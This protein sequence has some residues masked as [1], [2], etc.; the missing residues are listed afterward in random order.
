MIWFLHLQESTAVHVSK[1]GLQIVKKCGFVTFPVGM[2]KAISLLLSDPK[3]T[4]NFHC[5][6]SVRGPRWFKISIR[7][8]V[9][10]MALLFKNSSVVICCHACSECPRDRSPS[11]FKQTIYRYVSSYKTL[12]E[13]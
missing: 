3:H 4:E 12:T 6:H 5:F 10:E 8:V 9:V 1:Y 7:H 2:Y 13:Q 11:P